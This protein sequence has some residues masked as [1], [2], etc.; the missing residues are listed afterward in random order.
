MKLPK[1]LK[2]I[3]FGI[4]VRLDKTHEQQQQELKN[5]IEKDNERFKE[6]IRMDS[7]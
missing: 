2:W 4:S 6:N 1:W 3:K 7:R 5:I